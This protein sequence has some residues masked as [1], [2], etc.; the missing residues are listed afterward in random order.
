MTSLALH[1]CNDLLTADLYV[2]SILTIQAGFSEFC[3]ERAREKI[4]PLWKTRRQYS[5]CQEKSMLFPRVFSEQNN[6]V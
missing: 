5:H 2:G 4:Q 1:W 6:P 3:E